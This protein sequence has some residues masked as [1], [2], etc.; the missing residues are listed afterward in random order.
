MAPA[1]SWRWQ[2]EVASAMGPHT[3][4]LRAYVPDWQICSQLGGLG[5]MLLNV[6]SMMLTWMHCAIVVH[7]TAAMVLETW[8]M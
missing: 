8:E 6:G 3:P 1:S 7:I 2:H 4:E 5:A